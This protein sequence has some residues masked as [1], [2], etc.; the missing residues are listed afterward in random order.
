MVFDKE[1]VKHILRTIWQRKHLN[2][3]LSHVNEYTFSRSKWSVVIEICDTMKSKYADSVGKG[4]VLDCDKI[5]I[6]TLSKHGLFDKEHMPHEWHALTLMHVSVS[7]V[8]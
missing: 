7:S 5:Q 2:F 1:N 8:V 4:V 6:L 3:I